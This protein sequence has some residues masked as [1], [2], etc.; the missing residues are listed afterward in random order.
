MSASGKEI[1]PSRPQRDIAGA[2]GHN[3][4]DYH[5]NPNRVGEECNAHTQQC[6]HTFSSSERGKNGIDMTDDGQKSGQ[7]LCIDDLR[8]RPARRG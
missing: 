2:K 6:G 3:G 4:K 5:R 8:N 7:Y 1:P